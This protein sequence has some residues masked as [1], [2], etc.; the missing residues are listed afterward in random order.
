MNVVWVNTKCVMVD[1]SIKE[2]IAV[3]GNKGCLAVQWI[4]G[5]LVTVA[6]NSNPDRIYR[7]YLRAMREGEGNIGPYPKDFEF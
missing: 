7:A 5:V 2:M 3:A 4:N 1:E 6:G